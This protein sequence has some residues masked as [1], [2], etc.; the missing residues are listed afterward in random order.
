MVKKV[1]SAKG[2]M[3]D[4]DLFAIKEQIANKNKSKDAVNREEFVYSK[5][6]RG[7][8]RTLDEM[9]RAQDT[10]TASAKDALIKQNEDTN[11]EVD[12]TA[13]KANAAAPIPDSKPKRRIIKKN[14]V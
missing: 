1:R 13:E 14:K 4:F 9:K 5:R 7:S 12:D 8:K 2:E 3:V 6:R 11:Q 10:S